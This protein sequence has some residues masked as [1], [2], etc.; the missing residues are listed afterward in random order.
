ML[1]IGWIGALAAATLVAAATEASASR[2]VRRT[3]VGCVVETTFFSEDGYVI[4]VNDRANAPVDLQ[5]WRGR[6]LEIKGW[7]SPG[8]R[9]NLDGAPRVLGPC[10]PV[11]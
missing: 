11:R 10:K 4:R 1:R 5:R 2:P 7:L 6:R 8:D 3:I 9:F